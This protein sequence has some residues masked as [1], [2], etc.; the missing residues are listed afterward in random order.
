MRYCY[1]GGM[2]GKREVET[3]RR[4][5]EIDGEIRLKAMHA[6]SR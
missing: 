1:A 4:I 2:S 6:C 5:A 3:Y